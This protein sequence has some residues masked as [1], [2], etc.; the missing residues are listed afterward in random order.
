MCY[1]QLPPRKQTRTEITEDGVESVS[2]CSRMTPFSLSGTCPSCMTVRCC[3]QRGFCVLASRQMYL[4]TVTSP[5]NVH[6]YLEAPVSLICNSLRLSNLKCVVNV[7][8]ERPMTVFCA[9]RI[10]A[11]G[12]WVPATYS[13]ESTSCTTN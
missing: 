7:V 1:K 10:D 4:A 8:L 2:K 13:K 12:Q 9:Y 6:S 5:R 3:L 11:A